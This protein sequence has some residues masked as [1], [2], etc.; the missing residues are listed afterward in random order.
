MFPSSDGDPEAELAPSGSGDEGLRAAPVDVV[1]T[2]MSFR[3]DRRD[4][5]RLPDTRT[6]SRSEVV[7]TDPFALEEEE[8]SSKAP[9]AA[10]A[11]VWQ[12]QAYF[13]HQK[14]VIT[15]RNRYH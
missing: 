15:S 3:R 10:L 11:L 1:G 13:R 9:R 2:P 5:V 8:G 12:V 14:T 4:V 7:V 6:A